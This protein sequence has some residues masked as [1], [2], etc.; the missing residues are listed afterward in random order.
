MT[1]VILV[2]SWLAL[3]VNRFWLV[4]DMT[5]LVVLYQP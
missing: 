4:H 3:F 1:I 5:K 2:Q